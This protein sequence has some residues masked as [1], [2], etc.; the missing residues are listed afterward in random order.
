MNDNVGVVVA[1]EYSTADLIEAA[2]NSMEIG[3]LNQGY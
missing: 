2:S 3:N 1:H